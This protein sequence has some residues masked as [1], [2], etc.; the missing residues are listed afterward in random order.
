MNPRMDAPAKSMRPP[1]TSV[2][3]II[4]AVKS[5]LTA[6]KVSSMPGTMEPANMNTTVRARQIPPRA[7]F[8]V[9]VFFKFTIL[10]LRRLLYLVTAAVKAYVALESL[11]AHIIVPAVASAYA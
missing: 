9:F 7:S 4:T 2:S 1:R 11:T 5:E 6:N 8:D 3:N 10:S